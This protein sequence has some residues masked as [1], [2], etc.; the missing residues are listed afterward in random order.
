MDIAS[1]KKSGQVR[2]H[3]RPMPSVSKERFPFGLGKFGVHEVAEATYGD[4]TALTGFALAAGG[5]ARPGAVFW[6]RQTSIAGEH[7]ACLQRS[8]L[9]LGLGGRA[10]LSVQP[11]KTLDA[12]WTIEEAIRSS[13]TGLVIGEIK[14]A[15]FTATR[16]LTLA[17]SRYGVPV[18]LLLP[19]TREGA[20]AATA[21][22]RVM[23]QPSAPN[24]YDARG[25]GRPRW[26]AALERCRTH[27]QHVGKVFDME[28]D[29]ETL[30]LNLVSRL[31][32]RQV[33]PVADAR[34]QGGKTSRFRQ[35]G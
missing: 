31:A 1:L 3:L 27:P 7:G 30:S 11:R 6:V 17:A 34:G 15:D 24:R 29:D 8:L 12:L 5:R 19:Y 2:T 26:R 21:R 28:Y 35:V 18:I 33:A 14:E 20:T 22:W 32:N 4:M 16:R 13:A 10:C 25:L 9:Q 23:A